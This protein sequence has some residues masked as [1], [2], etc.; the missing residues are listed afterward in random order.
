MSDLP[1]GCV[2][3][4]G[5]AG[6]FPGAADLDQ[7]W[8]NLRDG[9]E[10]IRFFDGGGAAG[11]VGGHPRVVRAAG[12]L[13]DID[14]FA[15]G[16]FGFSP[17]E[18][19]LMDPQQRLFLESAW[20]AIESAGYNAASYPG[21]IG[22]Y[23]GT[24]PSDYLMKN[25]AMA[26]SVV[27]TAG[28]LPIML[29]N[30]PAF[31][32]TRVS[33]KL[34]LKGPAMYVGTAC[35]SSLV[36]VQLATHALATYQC[37]MAL[38]GGV[39]IGV[40]PERGYVFQEGGILSPDGHCRAFDARARGTV[41]GSGVGVVLL[42]RLEEALADGDVVLAVIRGAAVNN[43]GA[44]KVGYT[45]PNVAA[46]SEVIAEAQAAAGVQPDE[47]TYVEA[48]GT[49]T[50]LGD[51]IEIAALTRAF[52]AAT[53]RRGFCAIGS[54][55]T[56]IGHLDAAAG[57][58]GLIKVVLALRHRLLP[59][60]LHFES[61]NPEIDFS[62]SPFYVNTALSPWDEGAAPRRAGVSSF[63]IGGT[64]VHVVLEE[65]PAL[66][67]SGQSRPSQLLVLSA[68]T[69]D[70]LKKVTAN[71]ADHLRRNPSVNLA[72]VAFTLSTGR[73]AFAHRS[74]F[75]CHDSADAAVALS[76][77]EPRQSIG[78]DVVTRERVP[79]FV[80]S[81]Q[82]SQYEGMAREL[83]ER[84]AVFRAHVDHAADILMRRHRGFDLVGALYPH[85]RARSAEPKRTLDRTELTQPALFVLEYALAR[86]LMDWGI[87]PQVMIGY[88]IGE[89][90][91]ACLAGVFT[92]EDALQIV[93]ERGRLV[94]E[95]PEGSMLAIR[96]SEREARAVI[97]DDL[98]LAAVL[99]PSDC[100]VAGETPAI[101]ALARRL[102]EGGISTARLATS[103]AFHS[104]MMAPAVDRL[105]DVVA[106]VSL[107]P[108]AIPVLSNV[109]GRWMTAE[110][111][112]SPRYWADHLRRTVRFAEGMVEMLSD[113]RRVLIE[114]GPGRTLA[115][116]VE[117]SARG[118]ARPRA[119][120]L[121]RRPRDPSSDQSYL[122]GALGRLWLAGLSINWSGLFAGE[123]RRRTA[124][125]TYPFER[126]RYWI[127]PSASGS[128]AS[129][130]APEADIAR[131]FYVPVWKQSIST[132][133][134]SGQR[135]PRASGRSW[136]V[137]DGERGVGRD[138]VTRLRASGDEV[139]VVARG[140]QFAK[141]EEHA[142]TLDPA[143]PSDYIHL[144]DET[145][146]ASRSRRAVLYFAAALEGRGP[147][148]AELFHEL[149]ALAQ[150][151]GERLVLSSLGA[152]ADESQ[153]PIF[154]VTSGL[155]DVTGAERPRPHDAAVLGPVRVI[156][157]EYPG[158]LCRNIDVDPA[159]GRGVA[160]LL[161]EIEDVPSDLLV[162]YRGEHRW[163]QAFEQ[164]S[165]EPPAG[166]PPLLRR[167]GVYL[168]TGGLGGIG[169]VL[170]G[171]LAS[172]VAAKLVLVGRSDFP[173]EE[174]WDDL[175]ASSGGSGAPERTRERIRALRALQ[176]SGAELLV[177]RAD[178]ADEASMREVRQ[179]AQGRFGAI[180]GVIHAAGLPPDG[181]IHTKTREAAERVLAPK[182][183]GGHV[184]E[185]VFGGDALDFIVLCSSIQAYMGPPGSV[186]YCAA[187]IALDALAVRLCR[188]HGHTAISV[189][190][191]GWGK[192]GM[193]ADAS[194]VSR[195]LP[196]DLAHGGMTP[197][198]GIEVFR[199]ILASPRPHVIVS[200][201]DFDS[202]LQ[203]T[204]EALSVAAL[205]AP[206]EKRLAGRNARQPRPAL[207]SE[208]VAPKSPLERA[209]ADILGEL[210]G[211]ADIGVH[212]NF[213][214]LGADSL[215]FVQMVARAHER[216]IRLDSRR[217]F[218]LD[219]IAALAPTLELSP[220]RRTPAKRE[221][222]PVPL[223]PIQRAFFAQGIDDAR[224]FD[225]TV[226][227]ESPVELVQERIE[228]A[229]ECVLE[230]HDAF[231]LRFRRHDGEWTQE[232]IGA[233]H[234]AR[235]NYI[236]LGGSPPAV[237]Q[238]AAAAAATSL[239]WE[240]DPANGP[241]VRAALFSLG[242]DCGSRLLLVVHHL[243]ADIMSLR[244][245]VQDLEH[246]YRQLTLGQPVQLP[247]ATA[248]FR[249]WAEKVDRLARAGAF[250]DELDYWL[251]QG[252]AGAE[253]LPGDSPLPA[254]TRV[255]SASLVLAEAETRALLEAARRLRVSMGDLCLSSLAL[256]LAAR[257]N[258]TAHL[259]DVEGLGRDAA[260][261]GEDL[262]VSR[263]IGWFT[264]I[265]P[266][267]I[268]LG[269]A[270]DLSEALPLVRARLAE[271][272]RG[273]VGYG[274]LRCIDPDPEIRT[275]LQ[276]LPRA[277]VSFLYMGHVDAGGDHDALFLPVRET[278][279]PDPDARTL[280][281]YPLSL[282]AGVFAG[283]LRFDW[284]Y[285]EPG[286]DEAAVAE[287]G[288]HIAG[289]LRAFAAAPKL[290]EPAEAS[291]SARQMRSLIA[292]IGV[293]DANDL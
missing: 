73:K 96:L 222:G 164:V 257:T 214:E 111:A 76:T 146:F 21:R 195:Y 134:R 46:Q 145:R 92:L 64:N 8:T 156:N 246:A 19:E 44:Q 271:I 71:L 110:E 193:G 288:Q 258:R 95:L 33:Y 194:D 183:R 151:L 86:T 199:R 119:V 78:S 120:S 189:A 81:G 94:G 176:A 157:Q 228:R 14:R 160:Q 209:L 269:R 22:V 65:A 237:H 154:V 149:L 48:H 13:D 6:R 12:A 144:L 103:H 100:V 292:Q 118:G 143:R 161:A 277:A 150:A 240:L 107:H 59:A 50:P 272:P 87:H 198:E 140:G 264:A 75:V 225:L 52:R 187:N 200:T 260:L 57:I 159:G 229:L 137:F 39:R 82:G 232:Q 101:E 201:R 203:R 266:L 245:F 208:Y 153:T 158:I 121:L 206:T 74:A 178:V 99:G 255:A 58:A 259:V 77:A 2:A 125:P 278:I 79:A 241:L 56:N 289:S 141:V 35:S 124:L 102:A 97:G 122:L 126:H 204:R 10:S 130:L 280:G 177:L 40:F 175:L 128:K 131:W 171:Y 80:F 248:S 83:Y 273:G 162:A 53:S 224:H 104:R 293:V 238:A 29:G 283:A 49:G 4:I 282:T 262:D 18:A 36:A 172:A 253:D 24:G 168:I 247:A 147:A 223:T 217:L 70:A 190:W 216:G 34:D 181:L 16:F 43:D 129:M 88:S 7:F 230:H 31:L 89:Y 213:F 210:L 182:V 91:A 136:L 196:A 284:T 25:I 93:V 263:T 170:A 108:P 186:D 51:P 220:A 123:H 256:A 9:V 115:P 276:A 242:G 54:L 90:V 254:E 41:P 279:A 173:P 234:L 116:W 138:V 185:A 166:E 15:A 211:F 286:F 268:D 127:E 197:R 244:I 68:E 113:E 28:E 60:S 30:D 165:L 139:V 290:T 202:L 235:V 45:A 114:V 184:I 42:K 37:D 285:R 191:D 275:R 251:S 236:D 26:P 205:I 109:T 265:F 226:V 72:D 23:A 133:A 192:L 142:Y 17:R 174:R 188:V 63:G 69:S 47:I 27:Q 227:L 32:A 105:A 287:I 250:R 148:E 218:E 66:P 231:G 274:V 84:E 207:T 252:R 270:R 267:L 117:R 38:A 11:E 132:L 152:G 98:C 61:S 155:H 62:G 135:T 55:K 67:P 212:D 239:R 219:T 221:L 243:I 167:Q 179:H 106:G 180:H 233:T 20:E 5:M 281:V 169:L 215:S 112:T 249:S 261:A 1:V 85:P 163:V 291:L 3:I